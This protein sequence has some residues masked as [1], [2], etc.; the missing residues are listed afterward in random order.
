ML[1]DFENI[2]QLGDLHSRIAGDEVQHAVVRAAEAER[3]QNLVGVAD[4]VA[5]GKEEELDQVPAR[6]PGCRRRL[7]RRDRAKLTCSCDTELGHYV[8]YIDIFLVDC[9]PSKRDVT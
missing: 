9:Y 8:S 6:L 3:D 2:E 4:E 7:G 5:I 1:G